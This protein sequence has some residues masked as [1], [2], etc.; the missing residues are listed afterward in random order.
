M[1]TD[2]PI[3]FVNSIIKKVQKLSCKANNDVFLKYCIYSL[4]SFNNLQIIYIS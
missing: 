1:K 3:L 4:L 2:N